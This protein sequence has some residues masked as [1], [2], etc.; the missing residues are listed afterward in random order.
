MTCYTFLASSKQLELPE[1]I[2][3]YTKAVIYNDI[4]KYFNVSSL[5][6]DYYAKP[7]RGDFNA[8]VFVLCQGCWK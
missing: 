3:D 2:A 8:P 4:D 1:E 6:G 7:L 5:E